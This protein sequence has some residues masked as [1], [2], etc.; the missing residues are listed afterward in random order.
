M[1]TGR[2][3]TTKQVLSKLAELAEGKYCSMRIEIMLDGIETQIEYGVYVDGHTWCNADNW[4]S[5][6]L[7]LEAEMGEGV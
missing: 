6:L 2:C 1:R 4:E 7:E 5:A 3:M